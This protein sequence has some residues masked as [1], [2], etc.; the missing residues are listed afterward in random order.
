MANVA[1]KWLGILGIG[2]GLLGAT[3]CAGKRLYPVEGQVVFEDDGTPLTGGWI[4][5]DPVDVSTTKG[6]WADIQPDGRFHLGTYQAGDGAM[7]GKYRVV[8]RPPL[9][10]VRSRKNNPRSPVIDPSHQELAT[11]RLEFTVTSD[12]AANKFTWKVKRGN[13]RNPQPK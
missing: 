2:F 12:P 1:G 10:D 8:I 5:C 13:Q 4:T 11:S 3:G 6:A 9:E 7:E